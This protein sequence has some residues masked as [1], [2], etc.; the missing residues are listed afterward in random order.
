MQPSVNDI[1]SLYRGNPAPLQQ[2]VQRETQQNKGIPQDLKEL[3]ALQMLTEERSSMERQKAIDALQQTQGEPTV[4]QSVQQRA[5]QAL[6]AR[7]AQ[8]MQQ[9][10]AMQGMAQQMRPQGIPAGIPQPQRQPE[11]QGMYRGGVAKFSAGEKVEEDD[12]RFYDA[13]DYL[14]KKAE[15]D[16]RNGVAKEKPEPAKTVIPESVKKKV[17]EIRGQQPAAKEEKKPAGLPAALPQTSPAGYSADAAAARKKA[18]T[19]RVTE[20]PEI[21]AQSLRDR[22][23]LEVGAPDTSVY[24]QYIKE[25]EAKRARAQERIAKEDPILEY[26]KAIGK[27]RPGATWYEAILEGGEAL[28]K[29]AQTRE[30]EDM[31]TLRSILE[32]QGKKAEVQRGHRKD[33]FG[34]TQTERERVYKEAFEAS[35][36]MGADDRSAAQL[37][38]EAVLRREQIAASKIHPPTATEN[39][40]N[41]IIALRK[42]GRDKEADLLEQTWGRVQGS[43]AA[44]VGS[45]RNEINSLRAAIQSY[46]KIAE[47]LDYTDEERASA[48]AEVFNLTRRLQQL[49][50]QESGVTST[51]GG[52]ATKDG[53]PVANP[54]QSGAVPPPPAGFKLD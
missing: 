43:G 52:L 45:V 24:D 41:R 50:A 3:L 35:K 32:Q 23:A 15:E 53:R 30:E 42:Q 40:T 8:E 13:R 34:L 48:R 37:A 33:V 29:R 39:I 16:K 27:A 2:K 17:A 38:Q 11:V 47:N 22:Y 20:D 7:K 10:A 5:Q 12:E 51:P 31:Q 26:L 6:Q 19:D 36:E 14:L 1:A 54:A 28:D 21:A 46:Q 9:Q 18:L 25:L 44:G 49:E 4:A